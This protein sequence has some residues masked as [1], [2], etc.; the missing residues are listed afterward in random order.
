[1]ALEKRRRIIKVFS[2]SH[3]AYCPQLGMLYSRGHS[4]KINSLQ[5]KSLI[6]YGDKISSFQN[7][8]MKENSMSIHE[9]N[10]QPLA[11]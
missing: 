2:V 4:C 7:L 5:K 1:M 8:V 11:T 9:R 6:T 10:L 3:F